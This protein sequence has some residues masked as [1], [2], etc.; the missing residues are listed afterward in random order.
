MCF[1]KKN[2]SEIV[3]LIHCRTL[4]AL[5]A[6]HLPLQPPQPFNVQTWAAFTE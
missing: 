4:K 6:Q 3:K 5:A 2:F 1:V